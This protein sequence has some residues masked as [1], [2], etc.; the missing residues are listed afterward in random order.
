MGIELNGEV[1]LD[2]LICDGVML[3]TPAGKASVYNF[4]AHGPILP[5]GA[6]DGIDSNCSIPATALA[7]CC[8]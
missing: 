2:E 5:L 7:R 6:N 4:P 8:A 1:R 3:A